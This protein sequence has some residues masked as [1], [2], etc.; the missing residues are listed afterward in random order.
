MTEILDFIATHWL[1]WLF[2]AALAL[3]SFFLKLLREQLAEEREK[4]AA[5]FYENST[6]NQ[7]HE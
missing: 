3:I 5:R 4:N 2:T 6:A 1:E 7:N